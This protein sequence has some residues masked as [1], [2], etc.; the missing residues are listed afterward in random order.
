MPVRVECYAGYRG[1]E[2]PRRFWLGSRKIE[3]KDVL[4]RWMAPDH[5]YFKILGDDMAVYILR[6]DAVSWV[7]ELTFYQQAR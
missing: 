5:R 6:H 3:V 2:T 7:W 1:E 4:D